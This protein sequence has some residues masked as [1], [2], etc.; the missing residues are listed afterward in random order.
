MRRGKNLHFYPHPFPI[1]IVFKLLREGMGGGHFLLPHFFFFL[2][3]IHLLFL[4]VHPAEL[5]SPLARGRELCRWLGLIVCRWHALPGQTSASRHFACE[6][7]GLPLPVRC[8][9]NTILEPKKI[10]LLGLL[11]VSS[12]NLSWLQAILAWRRPPNLISRLQAV[13]WFCSPIH[14]SFGGK[15][16]S[17]PRG[18]YFSNFRRE[19]LGKFVSRRRINFKK[20]FCARLTFFSLI[21]R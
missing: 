1:I 15:K 4:I 16:H 17:H 12:E 3:F 14:Q 11:R 5:T 20:R 2:L 19:Q 8:L 21:R 9:I 6:V 7:R 18:L 10:V 13:W